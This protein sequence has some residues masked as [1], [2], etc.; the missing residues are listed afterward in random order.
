M[1]KAVIDKTADDYFNEIDPARD[2]GIVLTDEDVEDMYD[3]LWEGFPEH[4]DIRPVESSYLSSCL[5]VFNEALRRG[6]SAIDYDD[7]FRVDINGTIVCFY[8][9]E[10]FKCVAASREDSSESIAYLRIDAYDILDFW[11][12]FVAARDTFPAEC[13]RR[14]YAYNKKVLLEKVMFP[15]YEAKVRREVEMTGLS[16]SE[17]K[18]ELCCGKPI[19]NCGEQWFNLSYDIPKAA[20]TIIDK[21]KYYK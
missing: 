1:L 2:G 17:Y 5:D 11:E 9:Y 4:F 20:K 14:A 16:G 3:R 15:E 7:D 6:Y 10:P 13:R 21:L 19:C 8:D 12:E 18:L